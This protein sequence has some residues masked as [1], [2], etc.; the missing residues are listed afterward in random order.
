MLSIIIPT[1]N[2]AATL[3]RTLRSV[4]V[5]IFPAE[6][7]VSDGGSTDGTVDQARRARAHV[8]TGPAGRGGQLA[9]GADAAVGGWLLFLHADTC[10]APGWDEAAARFME[11]PENANMAAVF[12]LRLD[13]DAPAARRI[14]RL[15]N[16]RARALGLPYGDQGLL[17]SR[18]FYRSLGGFDDMPLMED[19]ALVRRIGRNRLAF[20]DAAAVTSAD[21]YRRDGYWLRPL[22]NLLCLTLYFCGAAPAWLRKVYG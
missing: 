18:R 6:V 14:E 15:A 3:R 16:W 11:R 9:R 20:L 22:K 19:V 4:A 8:V 17:I 2:A 12:R 1:L 10:L 13:D 7:V 5:P 21:R